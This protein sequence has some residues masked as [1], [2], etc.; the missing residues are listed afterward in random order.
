MKRFYL[1]FFSIG[2]GILATLCCLPA[3][4]ILVFGVSFSFLSNFDF[5]T[6]YRVFFTII[7]LLL[8]VLWTF[9]FLKG[10]K[11]FCSVFTCS[12]KIILNYLIILLLFLLL[13]F[14]PEILGFLY[15]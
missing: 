10:K 4:L 2:T 9:L 11:S 3:L 12:K 5:L 15:E 13:L 6:E 7:S 1:L 14:Y 8:F